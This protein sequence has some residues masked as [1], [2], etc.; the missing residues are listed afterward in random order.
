MTER[1]AVYPGS[2]DPITRGHEDIVRR[3]L[4]FVDRVI[5]AVAHQRTQPKPGLFTIAERVELIRSVFGSEPRVTATDFTGLL[6]DFAR[7]E[8][9]HHHSRPARRFGLRVRVPDGADEPSALSGGADDLPGARRALLLP[10]RI[11]GARDRCA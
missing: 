1:V 9:A 7:A 8:R 2:F 10:V 11:A 4:G 3:A 6:V 5:V